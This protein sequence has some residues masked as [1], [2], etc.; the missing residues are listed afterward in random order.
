[1]WATAVNTA[2]GNK[3]HRHKEP[4]ADH[5]RKEDIPEYMVNP[6]F[7]VMAKNEVKAFQKFRVQ[8]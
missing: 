3:T 1:M 6:S 4:T 8:V 2:E 5:P 7:F